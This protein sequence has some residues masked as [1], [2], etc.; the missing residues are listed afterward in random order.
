[1]IDE[2]LSGIIGST[3]AEFVAKYIPPRQ[4]DHAPANGSSEI[5][6]NTY[7][8]SKYLGITAFIVAF[9]CLNLA[10]PTD[11]WWIAFVAGLPFF[12]TAIFAVTTSAYFGR[13]QIQDFLRF[14]ELKSKMH[15]NCTYV[16]FSLGS[17]LF[18]TSSLMLIL[19][20]AEH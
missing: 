13:N 20:W 17:L 4:L 11:P 15:I 10:W 16:S 12:L 7:K 5:S 6:D 8:I 18:V 2:L 19:D 9:I 1:M 14:Y 3:L